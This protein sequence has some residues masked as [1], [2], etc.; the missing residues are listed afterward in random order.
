[1]LQS[2][3]TGLAGFPE[4]TLSPRERCVLIRV[5]WGKEGHLF[6]HGQN[7]GWNI[8]S[9]GGTTGGRPGSMDVREA[10]PTVRR[11]DGGHVSLKHPRRGLKHSPGSSD[12]RAMG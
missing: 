6:S 9:G 11:L 2:I 3:L 7:K 8:D 1:M 5:W 4:H 12:Q 10:V